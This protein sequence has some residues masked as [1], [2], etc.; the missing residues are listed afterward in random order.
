[1]NL[2]T[3]APRLLL[4]QFQ[5]FS[6]SVSLLSAVAF[7]LVLQNWESIPVTFCLCNDVRLVDFD[8]FC[9]PSVN[10]PVGWE[11]YDMFLAKCS[12]G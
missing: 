12:R 8:A 7:P 11:D 3:L 9:E 6:V 4:W 2:A 10:W 5:T 1:M